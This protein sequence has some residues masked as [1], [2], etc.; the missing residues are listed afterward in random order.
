M[1]NLTL[2]QGDLL[3]TPLQVARMTAAIANGGELV[4]PKLVKSPQ[5]VYPPAPKIELPPR[6]WKSLQRAMYSAVNGTRGT[7]F[8]ARGPGGRIHGKT[9]SAQNPH[10]EAHSWFTGY[11]EIPSGPSLVVTVLVEQ[12]GLGSRIAAPI[13]GQVFQKY[14]ALYQPILEEDIAA[15]N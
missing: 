6:I 3:V 2:G 14:I 10:G 15:T 8:R 12:G 5:L 11:V 9:G 13:A 1:L 4:I 7:G